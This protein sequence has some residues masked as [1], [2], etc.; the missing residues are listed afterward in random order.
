MHEA[1]ED[2]LQAA[3]T[4]E[5]ITLAKGDTPQAVNERIEMWQKIAQHYLDA[6]EA[7]DAVKW[8]NQ[9]SRE[10]HNLPED[11]KLLRVGF[12]GQQAVM[13]DSRR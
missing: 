10:I 11:A 1:R 8:V 3:T 12:H 4:L 2:Y 9:Q 7:Q 13:K 6:D 5:G